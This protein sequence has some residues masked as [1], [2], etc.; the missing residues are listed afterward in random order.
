MPRWSCN[1]QNTQASKFNAM[2]KLR[3]KKYRPNINTEP[4]HDNT[5]HD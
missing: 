5:E 2:Q 4:K 3:K 1:F